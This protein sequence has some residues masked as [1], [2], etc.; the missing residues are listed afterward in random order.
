MYVRK[1]TNKLRDG[2]NRIFLTHLCGMCLGPGAWGPAGSPRWV[3]S[4]PGDCRSCS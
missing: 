3:L 2:D 4:V 1:H